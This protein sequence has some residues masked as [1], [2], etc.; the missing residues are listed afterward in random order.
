MPEISS[1]YSFD[2]TILLQAEPTTNQMFV[3]LVNVQPV[4]GHLNVPMETEK[5]VQRVVKYRQKKINNWKLGENKEKRK[6]K[7]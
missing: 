2:P 6:G 7:R 4:V 1:S 5:A 3:Y